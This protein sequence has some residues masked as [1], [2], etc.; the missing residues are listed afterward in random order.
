MM[1]NYIR[2]WIPRRDQ[3]I[4]EI[5]DK[6][7]PDDS[8]CIHCVNQAIYRCSDCNG[9]PTSCLHCCLETHLRHPFHRI[10]QWTGKY[11][12]PSWLWKV[13]LSID[14]GHQGLP[15]PWYLHDAGQPSDNFIFGE[16]SET[17]LAAEDDSEEYNWVDPGKPSITNLPGK[18]PLT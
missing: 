6:A 1:Q 9:S 17:L 12:A 2:E 10:E 11:F 18:K 7:F 15:C 13:G 8:S 4:Q 3:Q 5:L 16:G 14:L